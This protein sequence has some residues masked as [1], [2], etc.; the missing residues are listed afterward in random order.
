MAGHRATWVRLR[1][2]ARERS[3]DDEL[4]AEIAMREAFDAE[5]A[6]AYA[7]DLDMQVEQQ[8]VLEAAHATTRLREELCQELWEK[9]TSAGGSEDDDEY[10]HLDDDD[11][12]A[13]FL[14]E[15]PTDP[16]AAEAAAERR[17][18]MA[19]FEMQHRDQSARQL[20]VAE[21]RVAADRLAAVQQRA[22]HSTVTQAYHCM[23]SMQVVDITP[24]KHRLT[25]ITSL[26]VVQQEHHRS[27][28]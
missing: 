11:L 21:R 8:G 7:T 2:L 5:E 9:G 19:S 16:E 1:E 20:M 28:A 6:V 25:S 18:L 4:A 17:A 14:V 26:K 12:D 10:L 24:M 23:C 27:K 3:L 13:D 15:L 22:R